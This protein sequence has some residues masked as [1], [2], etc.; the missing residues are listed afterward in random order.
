MEHLHNSFHYSQDGLFYA[1]N[2]LAG[3]RFNQTYYSW[4]RQWLGASGVPGNF[5]FRAVPPEALPE[6]CRKWG[7]FISGSIL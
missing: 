4:W 7:Y 3:V 5:R 2:R 1:L 6:W